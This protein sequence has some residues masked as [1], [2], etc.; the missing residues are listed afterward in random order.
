M[1]QLCNTVTHIIDEN[2]PL[3]DISTDELLSGEHFFVVLF[4]GLDSVISDTMVAR[5]TYHACDM[6]VGHHFVDNIKLAA[7]GLYID[8][9]AINDTVLRPDAELL[10]ADEDS[11]GEDGDNT[12]ESNVAYSTAATGAGAS[13]VNLI[14]DS[15][16]GPFVLLKA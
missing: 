6:L 7:D 16:R 5:K 3:Y 9:D 2:S 8:L 4:T 14:E 1:V 12:T 13:D 15:P 11:T 10:E